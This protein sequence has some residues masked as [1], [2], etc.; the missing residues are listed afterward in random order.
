MHIVYICDQKAKAKKGKASSTVHLSTYEKLERDIQHKILTRRP[1][2]QQL[3]KGKSTRVEYIA[4]HQIQHL[5]LKHL[6]S[7]CLEFIVILSE[8]HLPHSLFSFLFVINKQQI[9]HCR[10]PAYTAHKNSLQ[11]HNFMHA[12]SRTVIVFVLVYLSEA[13]TKHQIKYRF[14]TK[15][16]KRINDILHTH[17]FIRRCIHTKYSSIRLLQFGLMKPFINKTTLNHY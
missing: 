2:Q 7:T 17:Q 8:Q 5:R 11:L 13:I 12:F 15:T 1:H 9:A 6:H 4:S 16:R 10:N 14:F 3:N